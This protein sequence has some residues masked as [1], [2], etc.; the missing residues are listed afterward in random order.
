MNGTT[1][2]PANTWPVDANTVAQ[3]LTSSALGTT[4]VD[5]AGGDNVGTIDQGWVTDT[6]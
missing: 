3:F 5:E 1:F 6:P 4:L 2:T